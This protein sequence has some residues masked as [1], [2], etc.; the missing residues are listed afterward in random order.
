MKPGDPARFARELQGDFSE[1]D[2]YMVRE[3]IKMI[4]VAGALAALFL[5]AWLI[6]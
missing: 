6:P 4:L 5:I 1:F 2:A 3:R